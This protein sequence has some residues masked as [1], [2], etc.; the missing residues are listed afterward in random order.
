M[1]G[2]LTAQDPGRRF[3]LGVGNGFLPC[4]PVYVMAVG[5]L[6]AASPWLGAGAMALYGLGTLP[7]MVPAMFYVFA[8]GDTLTAVLFLVWGLFVGTIDNVLKPFF[9]GRG[10][11]VPI[12]AGIMPSAYAAAARL[13]RAENPGDHE[14]CAQV[15]KSH[16]CSWPRAS[17]SRSGSSRAT[18]R[19]S[20]W[21]STAPAP[22]SPTRI[23]SNS[24]G[25]VMAVEVFSTS[26]MRFM[27]LS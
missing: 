3:L 1:R 7:V 6:A 13:T 17:S 26:W 18:S 5:T 2:L 27:A 8:T 19:L 21:K 11:D 10:I 14:E 12:V 25:A 4:G 24:V 23:R 22:S 16:W 20:R 15:A 9:F